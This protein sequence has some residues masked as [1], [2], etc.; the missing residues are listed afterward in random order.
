MPTTRIRRGQIVTIPDNW[1]HVVPSPKTIRDRKV[2]SLLIK[3]ARKKR[4]RDEYHF[5]I[6]QSEFPTCLPIHQP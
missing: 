1:L 5:D 2:K 3:K 6:Q 4:L